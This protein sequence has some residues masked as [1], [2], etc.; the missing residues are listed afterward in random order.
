MPV[1]FYASEFNLM[2]G[3]VGIGTTTPGAKL[4][5][6]SDS[7]SDPLALFYYPTLASGS[8]VAIRVGRASAVGEAGIYGYKYNS[9]TANSYMWF[10]HY[11]DNPAGIGQD[12]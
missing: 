8:N 11:G 4:D 7:V 6:N 5:V 10:G 3:N 12:W 2:T 9:T 1:R